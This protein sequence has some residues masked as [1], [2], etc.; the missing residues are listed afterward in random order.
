MSYSSATPATPPGR[1]RL[2]ADDRLNCS[3]NDNV[4][5]EL[6]ATTMTRAFVGF[7]HLNTKFVLLLL[8]LKFKNYDFI[9]PSQI[10]ALKG[11]FASR[12]LSAL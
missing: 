6:S 2:S 3:E 10:G 12:S 4:T 5:S 11:R 1:G 7:C 9:R 8:N